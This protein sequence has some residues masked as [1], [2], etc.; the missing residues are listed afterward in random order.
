MQSWIITGGRILSEAMFTEA[1][2][3]MEAGLIA[4]AASEPRSFNAAGLLVLPGIIDLHGDAFE[5]QLQP[6]PNVDFDALFALVETERQLLGCG[7]TT[8][9]HGVTLSW[10]P[11]LRSL[12]A[13]RALLVA[14]AK[15]DWVCDMRIHLR[16][17]TYNLE[18]L[19]EAIAD[20]LA[21]RV[22]LLAFNDH[23]QGILRKLRNPASAAKFADRAGMTH[24]AFTELAHRIATRAD[25]V[26]AALDRLAQAARTMDLPMASH[27]DETIAMRQR[28]HALGAEICEFPT[29]IEVGRYAADLGQF[30]VMG[31]PNVVRGG[32]HTG[33]ESAADLA[34]QGICRVLTSDYFY[35]CLLEAPFEMAR[36]GRMDLATAWAMVSA[37]PAM[38]A[39][40]SDR[41]RLAPG[42]RADIVVVDPDLRTPVAT[43]V[44]GRLAWVS[45]EGAAR[46]G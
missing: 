46:L 37:N 9:Y 44:A 27:D 12:T 1:T 31:S 6:R 20:I 8:A 32:S 38:A 19:D 43:F 35:P 25:E 26:P 39:R 29:T 2:L 5:R 41:G 34:E 23:M 14:M 22:H 4:S 10:E 21:G 24:Q 45:A 3:H 42:L 13:W 7:I 11:G 15:R 16:F 28:Y 17:E 30:V 36:R 33:W 40:L 18:A